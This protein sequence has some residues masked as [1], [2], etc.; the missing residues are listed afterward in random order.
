MHARSYADVSVGELCRAADVHKGSFYH[1]FPSKADLG[2]AVL[3]RSWQLMT[4]V[5]D[6][7]FDTDVD[8]LQRIERFLHRF[9]DRLRAARELMGVVPGC[10]VGPLAAE[11]ATSG[12]D[13]ARQAVGVLDAWQRYLVDAIRDAHAAG[14]CAA[15][16][17]PRHLAEQVLVVIQG[18]ALMATIRDRPEVVE[19]SLPA[20]RA[21]LGAPR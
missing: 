3:D 6:E 10:P 1:F 21:L 5:L 11:L 16:E 2:R 20:I 12:E 19:E 15:T 4:E 13:P 17:G 8:P 14:Q 9:A 7:A 18:A